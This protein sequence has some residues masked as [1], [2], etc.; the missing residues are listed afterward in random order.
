V[1]P[2]VR[3][4]NTTNTKTATTVSTQTATLEVVPGQS[5][6]LLVSL[7]GRP[8]E[9]SI[10]ATCTDLPQGATCSYDDQNHSVMIIPGA[11][12]PPARYPIRVIFTVGPGTD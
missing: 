11:D 2:T 10:T 8:A 12:T 3:N 4:T 7:A 5:T 9:A 1:L 6:P